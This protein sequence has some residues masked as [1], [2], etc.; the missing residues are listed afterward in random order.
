[1]YVSTFYI[2]IFLRILATEL[3]SIAALLCFLRVFCFGLCKQQFLQLLTNFC[4]SLA[5]C[6]IRVLAAYSLSLRLKQIQ[7]GSRLKRLLFLSGFNQRCKVVTNFHKNP[8]Y[9]ILR[10]S[11]LGGVE[12]LLAFR[13]TDGQT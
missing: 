3:Q 12:L 13:Q 1:M 11:I 8:K 7:A 10:K 9:K 2:I 6:S 5:V 4:F